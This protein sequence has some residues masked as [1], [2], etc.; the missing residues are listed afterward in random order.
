MANP[1]S[2]GK[3]DCAG[4]RGSA[5]QRGWSDPR[6]VWVPGCLKI[7]RSASGAGRAPQSQ[8]R[9]GEREAVL[10]TYGKTRITEAENLALR[11]TPAIPSSSEDSGRKFSEDVSSPSRQE[12]ALTS[13]QHQPGRETSPTPSARRQ[14]GH[15]LCAVS[16]E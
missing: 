4:T 15:S 14:K 2:A 13:R 3:Q 11:L 7:P 5:T 8:G 1:F 6:L 10:R 16:W 12:P 9:K